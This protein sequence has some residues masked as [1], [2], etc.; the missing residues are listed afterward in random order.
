LAK[1]AEWNKAHPN[2]HAPKRQ[3]KLNPEETLDRVNFACQV[4]PIPTFLNATLDPGPAPTLELPMRM[5]TTATVPPPDAPMVSLLSAPPLG[6]TGGVEVTPEPATWLFMLTGA[7]FLLF[8]GKTMR[9]Q[10]TG[11]LSA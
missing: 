7:A 5:V 6:P 8:C 9:K 10:Q 2:Y 3:P 4:D 11:S 1:W